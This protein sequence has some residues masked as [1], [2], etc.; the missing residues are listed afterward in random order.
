[1]SDRGKNMFKMHWIEPNS[2]DK[3]V[4]V[5]NSAI[6]SYTV[7][8]L[9]ISPS[10]MW[11]IIWCLGNPVPSI[12]IWKANSNLGSISPLLAF[13]SHSSRRLCASTSSLFS[14]I[15]RKKQIFYLKNSH[16]KKTSKN[17]QI[18]L[19]SSVLYSTLKNLD[20]TFKKKYYGEYSS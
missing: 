14:I 19:L 15:W 13:R 3:I 16:T 2:F 12:N 9:T 5:V 11:S 6:C 8:K 10:N 17:C 20:C 1:M 7:T 18:V 4:K